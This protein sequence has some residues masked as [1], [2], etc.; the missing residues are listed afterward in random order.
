MRAL[1]IIIPRLYEAIQ[2]GAERI[3]PIVYA[4]LRIVAG[5]LFS[6]HGMQ[7]LFGWPSGKLAE[8]GSQM[9][10]GGVIEL[11]G[12]LLI[13]LGLFT[14]PAAFLASGT[15]AVAY[16]Q[17]HWKLDFGERFWPVI[18]RGELA[19]VYCF[20][21]LWVVVRGGGRYALDRLLHRVWTGL[22]TEDDPIPKAKIVE[23]SPS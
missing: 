21:F 5:V 3:E 8:L 16:I 6:F 18:N 17:F 9:W 12:G 14:R 1:A 10:I 13:A 4:A 7:K 2:R 22:E 15:M 20:L 23:R 19:V 11:V